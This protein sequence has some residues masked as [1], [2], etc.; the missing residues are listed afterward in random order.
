MKPGKPVTAKTGHGGQ[1]PVDELLTDIRTVIERA[2][3]QAITAVNT[4]QTYMYWRIGQRIH[5]EL[6]GGERAAYGAQIVA[7]LSRQLVQEYGR[8]FTE[9]NLRRMVQFGEK[10]A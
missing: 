6:L 7:T 4:S 3:Q 9:K 8:G 10:T 2:R 1:P 5:I